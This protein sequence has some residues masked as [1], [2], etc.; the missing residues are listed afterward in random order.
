[1]DW[2]WAPSSARK[3]TATR[4]EGLAEALL[5]CIRSTI[6]VGRFYQARDLF[7][8]ASNPN[9]TAEA[10]D[11]MTK[12]AKA[13]RENA[14]A[15]LPLVCADSRVGFANSGQM[16]QE[17]VPR[18][19]IYSPGSIEKKIEQVTRLIDVELPAMRKTRGLH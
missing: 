12:I 11:A 5:Y 13:E 2:P 10:L 7:E 18:A 19:G 16:D 4:E 14:K 17:G 3:R 6:N 15:A 1:M 9:R 8:N